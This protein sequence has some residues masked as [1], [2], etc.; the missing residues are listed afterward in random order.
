AISYAAL[1]KGERMRAGQFKRREF[2]MLIGSAAFARSAG[3]QTPPGKLRLGF[4][5]PVSPKNVPP[6]YVAFI[7]RLRELGYVEGDTLAVEDINLEGRTDRYDEAMQELVRRRVDLIYAVG[8]EA[9][10]RA[11]LAATSTIPIVFLA[12]AYDPVDKGYVASLARPTGNATGVFALATEAIKK[13]LQIFRDA[14]PETRAAFGFWD[15]D[16]AES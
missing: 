2:L 7:G 9:N 6:Y 3:A 10:L 13:R 8:Q 11:A 14:F 12:I 4:V 1:A 5:H 15:F 16:S